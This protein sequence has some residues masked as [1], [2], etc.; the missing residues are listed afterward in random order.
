MSVERRDQQNLN[1]VTGAF[2]TPRGIAKRYS[3]SEQLELLSS[4]W[5][6]IRLRAKEKETIFNN[7]LHH[8]NVETL[9]E[10]YKALDGSK[11]IGVD[12]ISKTEYGKNLEFNLKELV[13]RIHKGSYKPQVKREAFI[14]KADGRKRPLAIACFEDKLIEFVV[15]KVLEN[16]Y[17]PQFIRNSFGFRPKK[18]ADDAI[19]AC[20]Y[21]HKDNKRPFVVEIDFVNFFNTIPHR[22]VMKVLGYKISDKRF[23]GLIGRLLKVGILDQSGEVKPTQVG[24]PQGSIVSPILANIYLNEVLDQWFVNNYGSYSNIMVRYADD[25][26]FFFKSEEEAMKFKSDLEERVTL[27][28]LSLHPEKTTTVNFKR[29]ENNHFDFLSFRFFWGKKRRSV[30]RPLLI[31]TQK[32]QLLKKAQDFDHWIKEVR[33]RMRLKDI[34]ALAKSKL[35]G[36]YNYFGYWMNKQKLNHFYCEV[37]KSLFKWLN[38]RSQKASFTW[39]Q[40]ERKIKHHLPKPPT[41]SKLKPLGVSI[42]V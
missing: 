40:F 12:G 26:V 8:I 3:D 35:I 11:A 17:E 23:K 36:H 18:S 5:T 34:W 39:E 27:Y 9:S 28:G 41:M 24:T 13:E 29:S 19:K 20:Y 32:K 7:L 30:R 42:Y 37:K 6:R 15:A 21:S 31:K 33:S 22:K 1:L 38:R 14:P 25:A 16:I 2:N 4:R 10:A